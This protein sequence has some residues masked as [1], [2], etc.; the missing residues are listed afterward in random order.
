[1]PDGAVVLCC[2]DFGLRHELGNLIYNSYDE[3]VN[4]KA[5][6]EIKACM[7]NDGDVLCRKCSFAKCL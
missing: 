3:L 1:M 4:S 7:E 5:L 6:C 2:M